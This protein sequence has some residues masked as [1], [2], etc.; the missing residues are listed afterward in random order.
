MA[1]KTMSKG[2]HAT[3]GGWEPKVC[4]YLSGCL[5]GGRIVLSHNHAIRFNLDDITGKKTAYHHEC[6]HHHNHIRACG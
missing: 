5:Y 4:A 6:W 2:S 3:R 1:T